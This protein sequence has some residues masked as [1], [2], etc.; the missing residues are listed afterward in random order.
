MT[1]SAPE[2]AEIQSLD[3]GAD[4]YIAKSENT[5]ILI[6]RIIA[7]LR[8][9]SEFD[10]VLDSHGPGFRSASILIIDDSP[11]YLAALSHEM[12]NQGYKVKSAPSGADGL[13]ELQ[14]QRFDCVLVDLVMPCMT[15]FEVCR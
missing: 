13:K 2:T 12:R 7:L 14:S 15:G 9:G 4:G 10:A 5:D 3:S 8:K 6:L 1:S 11:S